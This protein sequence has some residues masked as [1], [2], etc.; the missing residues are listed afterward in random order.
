MELL[1]LPRRSFCVVVVRAHFCASVSLSRKKQQH[2]QQVKYVCK[3]NNEPFISWVWVET[4]AY[5]SRW[6]HRVFPHQ[7][8][9]LQPCKYAR[10]QLHLR[11]MNSWG[12]SAKKHFFLSMDHGH[13]MG[14]WNKA[15][16]NTLWAIQFGRFMYVCRPTYIGSSNSQKRISS[17]SALKQVHLLAWVVRELW[18]FHV[19]HIKGLMVC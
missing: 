18:L 14:T 9:H 17:L 7:K 4:I 1:L 8:V 13:N 16:M 19:K 10:A 12:I 3:T 15:V 11:P 2:G 6:L 5:L